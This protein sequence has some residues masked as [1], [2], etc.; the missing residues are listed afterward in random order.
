[1]ID[2]VVCRKGDKLIP[3]SEHD[4]Q[5]MLTMS[6]VSLLRARITGAKKERSY[7]EL[8]CYFGSCEYIASLNLNENMNTKDKADYLTRLRCD[9]VKEVVFDEHGLM[10][11]IPDD[12]NYENCDQ[13]KSHKFIKEALER[14]A[15]LAG[16]NDV[17]EYVKNLNEL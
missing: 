7:R 2:V 10:H 1:M 11:W 15:F 14:H 3:F 16:V 17:D 9:F 12:L 8:C 5:Q 4:R 13:P 6:S